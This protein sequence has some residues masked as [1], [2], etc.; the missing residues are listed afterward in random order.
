MS[1][2][3]Q[4]YPGYDRNSPNLI[5]SIVVGS[6]MSNPPFEIRDGD[7]LLFDSSLEI[8]SGDVVLIEC[9]TDG[10]IEGITRSVKQLEA[11]EGKWWLSCENGL[12]A[13]KTFKDKVLG[14][15]VRSCHL[16]RTD[17]LRDAELTQRVTAR[18]D[19]WHDALQARF[20]SAYAYIEKHGPDRITVFRAASSA[21]TTD[22]QGEFPMKGGLMKN[23]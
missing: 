22:A 5:L 10:A 3:Y 19:G 2:R 1:A 14:R 17:P 7:L 16:D 21:V 12:L 8:R 11:A 9:D 15:L 23:A 13:P 18:P 6:C 4:N 20:A